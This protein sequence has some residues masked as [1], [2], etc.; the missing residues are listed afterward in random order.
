VKVAAPEVPSARLSDGPDDDRA[1]RLG[2]TAWLLDGP[3]PIPRH[4][5]QFRPGTLG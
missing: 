5:A 3:S 4:D 1:A 2:Q